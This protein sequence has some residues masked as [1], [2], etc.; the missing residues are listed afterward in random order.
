MVR[1]M[2][3]RSLTGWLVL[4]SG[5]GDF[6]LPSGDGGV[7]TCNQTSGSV[8]RGGP[9]GGASFAATPGLDFPRGGTLCLDVGE[10]Y[11]LRVEPY[12]LTAMNVNASEGSP[13]F[14]VLRGG[15][16]LHAATGPVEG[17]AYAGKDPLDVVVRNASTSQRLLVDYSFALSGMTQSFASPRPLGDGGLGE[18]LVE[19]TPSFASAP[20]VPT[21]TFPLTLKLSLDR[22]LGEVLVKGSCEPT[23]AVPEH[24]V[25]VELDAG[26]HKFTD[27]GQVARDYRL[28][29]VG[30]DGGTLVTGMV[31][32]LA[33]LDLNLTRAQRVAVSANV[34]DMRRTCSFDG[35]AAPGLAGAAGFIVR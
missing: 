29:A 30:E 2:R 17:W 4:L 8:V 6:L 23:A 7:G 19:P 3:L 16:P 10:Q 12:S 15:A 9:D 32:Q 35:G 28:R 27:L 26:L 20:L 33:S 22:P 11:T 31:S 1:R 14:T 34:A 18:L 24:F 21:G 13:S 5:C 25:A